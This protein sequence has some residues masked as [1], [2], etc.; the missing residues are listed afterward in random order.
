MQVGTGKPKIK[1]NLCNIEFDD[2]MIS[3]S[4]LQTSYKPTNPYLLHHVQQDLF[5][6]LNSDLYRSFTE[7]DNAPRAFSFTVIRPVAFSTSNSQ[8]K[9]RDP[10]WTLWFWIIVIC[11]LILTPILSFAFYTSYYVVCLLYLFSLFF[12]YIIVLFV[13]YHVWFY[14]LFVVLYSMIK[15]QLV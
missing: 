6:R 7:S 5:S 2:V 10:G 12:T 15:H 4:F 3:V 9:K 1:F 14:K 8:R 13:Y 11:Y